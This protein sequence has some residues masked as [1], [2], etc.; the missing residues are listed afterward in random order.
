MRNGRC[1]PWSIP[2]RSMCDPRGAGPAWTAVRAGCPP[3]RASARSDP[4]TARVR[5]L[6]GRP[7][8]SCRRSPPRAPPRRRRVRRPATVDARMPGGRT[9]C[10]ARAPSAS[11]RGA[12]GRRVAHNSSRHPAYIHGIMAHARI[13]SCLVHRMPINSFGVPSSC[14]VDHVIHIRRRL[15]VMPSRTDHGDDQVSSFNFYEPVSRHLQ[16]SVL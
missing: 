10:A 3:P 16:Y 5:T 14:H 12:P 7:P 15:M 11:P 13:R 9:R 4:R 1:V 2:W 6:R 8:T